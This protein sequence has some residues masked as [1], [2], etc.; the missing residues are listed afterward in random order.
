MCDCRTLWHNATKWCHLDM[1][2]MLDEEEGHDGHELIEYENGKKEL[3][4]C[5]SYCTMVGDRI[6]CLICGEIEVVEE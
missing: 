4:H 6:K 3:V 1:H 2:D 5:T